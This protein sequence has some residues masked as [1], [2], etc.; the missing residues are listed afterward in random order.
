MSS[1]VQLSLNYWKSLGMRVPFL[2]HEKTVQILKYILKGCGFLFRF[3]Q[4]YATLLLTRTSV[5]HKRLKWIR[6]NLWIYGWL[7][8]PTH[9]SSIFINSADII[10]VCEL[11]WL[12]VRSLFKDQSH[13]ITLTDI[14]NSLNSLFRMHRSSSSSGHTKTLAY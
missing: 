10:V 3:C 14:N 6:V 4:M 7:S 5:T 13:I 12:V 2:M 9:N 11:L 8:W 1:N